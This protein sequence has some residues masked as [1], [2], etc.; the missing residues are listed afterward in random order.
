MPS[1]PSSAACRP[2]AR[3]PRAGA[4]A[5]AGKIARDVTLLAQGEVAEVRE[6]DTE[7]GRGGRPGP[8]RG[9]SSAMPHKRNPVAAIAT[10]GCT[11]QAPGLLATLTAAAEQ[12]H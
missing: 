12:E 6:G 4:C 10:L 5:A 7:T 2:P 3:R 9:G 11:R 8:R 1:A